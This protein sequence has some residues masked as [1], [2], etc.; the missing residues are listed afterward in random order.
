MSDN[1][2]QY[3]ELVQPH[4]SFGFGDVCNFV[5]V[6]TAAGL[7]VQCTA[8][9]RPDVSLSK[10]RALSSA[11]GASSFQSYPYHP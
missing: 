6:A 7:Q 8:V 5:S 2:K 4:A 11:L 10:V 1:P 9:E 3:A